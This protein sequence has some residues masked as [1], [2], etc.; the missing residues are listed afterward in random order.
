MGKGV[1]GL[2]R[3]ALSTGL[4]ALEG[5][6]RGLERLFGGGEKLTAEEGEEGQPGA[7]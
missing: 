1:A 4:G 6:G 2:G 5:L 3:D 7:E